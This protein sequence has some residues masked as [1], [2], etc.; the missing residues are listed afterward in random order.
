MPENNFWEIGSD[1][2]I[3]L[4]GLTRSD[5]SPLVG[6]SI[7]GTL[8]DSR[9]RVI[10]SDIVFTDGE[11]VGE[12]VAEIP[13]TVT[14][15]PGC[16]YHLVILLIDDPTGSPRRTTMRLSRPAKYREA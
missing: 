10:A 2:T 4:R 6:P 8:T 3:T 7:V 14:L 5:G 13:Y 16:E 11:L 12:Y 1:Q 15:V 9:G